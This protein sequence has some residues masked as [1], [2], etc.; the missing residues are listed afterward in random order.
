MWEDLEIEKYAFKKFIDDL[1]KING[2]R[3]CTDYRTTRGALIED[4]LP[5]IK[6]CEQGLTDHGP[7]HVENVLTNVYQ[8][9]G[10]EELSKLNACELY[11]LLISVLLHDVGNLH[12]RENH[13]KK[14][15]NIYHYVRPRVTMQEKR[16]VTRIVAA[17]AGPARDGSNDTLK[18]LNDT[19]E[20]MGKGVRVGELAALLRF[21]DELAEGPQRTSKYMIKMGCY[22]KESQIFHKYA[23][24]TN[25]YIDRGNY[26]IVL[27]YFL[28]IKECK[29]IPPEIEAEINKL[30]EF[31]YKRIVKMDQE[32]KF[33]KFYCTL[34]SPFKRIEV[35]YVFSIDG[36][37]IDLGIGTLI[38]DDLVVPGELELSIKERNEKFVAANII[39]KINEICLEQSVL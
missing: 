9:L 1:G 35:S 28:D 12:G 33:N 37:E 25:V 21:A 23:D 13:S 30:L 31:S 19:M 11:C 32:R 15:T 7:K 18:T 10:D 4:I 8:L 38:L 6:Y 36:H 26:R 2:E 24:I 22:P 5:E 20:F 17:H 34:L 16:I 27:T 14:I 3:L 29:S 39:K